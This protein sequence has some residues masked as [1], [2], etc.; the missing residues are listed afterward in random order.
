MLIPTGYMQ[1]NYRFTG[2]A[3]PH[4]A[5]F[6]LGHF[7]GTTEDDPAVVAGVLYLAAAQTLSRLWSADVVFSSVLCKFGPNATG[8]QGEASG[9]TAGS[10][11]GNADSPNT[12]LLVRKNTTAGGRTGRGRMYVPGLNQSDVGPAGNIVSASRALFQDDVDDFH[13][14]LITDGYPPFLLHAPDSP[15]ASPTEIVSFSVDATAATQ[16]RRLR[17]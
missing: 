14:R 4:G 10:A 12:A 13:A 6:T 11:T 2:T 3:L 8:A 1:A 16:R 7:K 15:V 17:R 5:E 9:V